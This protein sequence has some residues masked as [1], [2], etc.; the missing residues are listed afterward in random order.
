[1]SSNLIDVFADELHGGLSPLLKLKACIDSVEQ[2]YRR[3]VEKNI[4]TNATPTSVITDSKKKDHT[5]CLASNTVNS[6]EKN[7]VEDLRVC[8]PDSTNPDVDCKLEFN[9]DT[10]RYMFDQDTCTRHQTNSNDS[11]LVQLDCDRAWL[12]WDE[13][14]GMSIY[15]TCCCHRSVNN[16]KSG[17]SFGL[18]EINSL[19]PPASRHF[20][21]SRDIHWHNLVQPSDVVSL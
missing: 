4:S 7:A 17:H 21:T 3:S 10:Q 1:M 18:C 12:Q 20:Q 15:P 9:L 8:S 11:R 13:C 2:R 5:P 14:H 19:H 16:C 6:D